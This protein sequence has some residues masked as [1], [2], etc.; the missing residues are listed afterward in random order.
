MCVYIHAY[1]YVPSVC[2]SHQTDPLG[3]SDGPEVPRISHA[4]SHQAVSSTTH[5]L[6]PLSF[7]SLVFTLS[8]PL[9]L[10]FSFSRSSRR[11]CRYHSTLF[12]A[13][14]QPDLIYGGE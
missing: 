14:F 3:A 7:P 13:D 12:S 2:V 5:T 6:T 9:P 4:H 10:S 11:R 1:M 8:C